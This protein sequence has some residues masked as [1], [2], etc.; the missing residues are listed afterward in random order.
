MDGI[1][2][3]DMINEGINYDPDVNEFTE[4]CSNLNGLGVLL[5]PELY[6]ESMVDNNKSFTDKFKI[7]TPFK[8]T[9]KTTNDIAKAYGDV[10]DGGGSLIRSV[11]DMSMKALQFTT[12]IIKFILINM[13]KVPKMLVSVFQTIGRIPQNVRDKIRGNISLFITV[14]DVDNLY[15]TLIPSLDSFLDLAEEIAKGDMWGTFF[16]RRPVGSGIPS[17][18]ILT[19]NDMSYYKKMKSVYGKLKL[20]EFHETVIKLENQN[21]V[22]MYFGT[23]KSI[24]YTDADKRTNTSTYYDAL[25]HIFEDLQEQDGFLKEMQT[26]MNE[27]FDRSQ[28][29]QAFGRLNESAQNIVG[30]SIQMIS[31]VINIIGNLIR[32]V[33]T[34]IKTLRNSAAKILKSDKVPTVKNESVS[35]IDLIP[36]PGS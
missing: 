7:G 14:N 36:Q 28:M 21:V 3:L 9:R 29:N 20:I 34:D 30:E 2:N 5:S 25:I 15:K 11:W 8:N 19:E 33:M 1:L 23:S 4:F 27:K 12:R 26:D 18:Y 16:N 22:D 31:K 13:A 35:T 17:K 24:K 6:L 32:Y 10:T